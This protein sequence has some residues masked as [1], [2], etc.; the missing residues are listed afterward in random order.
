[1]IL[2]DIKYSRVAG[3]RECT[4]SSWREGYRGYNPTWS[5]QG[6]LPF[7]FEFRLEKADMGRQFSMGFLHFRMTHQQGM[8]GTIVL[9]YIF[10]EV[11]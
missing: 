4:G 3:Y 6:R 2:D 7:M 11:V 1:M 5:G 8:N 9:H 10:K